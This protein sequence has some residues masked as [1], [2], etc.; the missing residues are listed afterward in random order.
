MHNTGG[1]EMK[2]VG[3]IAHNDGV[4][5]IG[6]A[7]VSDYDVSIVS[8]KVGDFGLALISKLRSDDNYISQGLIIS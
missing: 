3:L 4:T 8:Q 6:T 7:L 5:S 2:L 1:D